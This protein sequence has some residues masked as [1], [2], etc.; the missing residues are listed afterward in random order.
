MLLCNVAIIN[1]RTQA[2]PMPIDCGRLLVEASR[3][4]QNEFI[5]VSAGTAANVPHSL[6]IFTPLIKIEQASNILT[7][8]LGILGKIFV[9]YKTRVIIWVRSG[10]EQTLTCQHIK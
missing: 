9:D 2:L 7:V 6:F 8:C 4:S 1:Q 5:Q 10:C 3:I